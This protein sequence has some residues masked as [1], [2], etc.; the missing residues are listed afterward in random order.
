MSD[1]PSS[2]GMDV[3]DIANLPELQDAAR[4]VQALRIIRL[5]RKH[6]LL[7]SD[8][9]GTNDYLLTPGVN[10]DVNGRVNTY[11]IAVRVGDG[12]MSESLSL[13]INDVIRNPIHIGRDA[14]EPP[15]MLV[16]KPDVVIATTGVDKILGE[17]ERNANNVAEEAEFHAQRRK[18]AI[19]KVVNRVWQP[20]KEF[21]E[22]QWANALGILAFLFVIGVVIALAG[23]GI[24]SCVGAVNRSNEERSRAISDFDKANPNMVLKGHRTD[25]G[26]SGT[27]KTNTADMD[28]GIPWQPSEKVDKY[29]RAY[30]VDTG[31]CSD[32][33]D[34]EKKFD[35]YDAYGRIAGH[36]Y[37]IMETNA[38][39]DM[40]HYW[41]NPTG[42]V[43]LCAT[44][45]AN[46]GSYGPD[47]T[48]WMQTQPKK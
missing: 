32:S 20:T 33:E 25:I 42:L 44:D 29:P 48:V 14:S 15:L 23:W 9:D 24:S 30:T 26:T 27:L 22:E 12:Q 46:E 8:N 34:N 2:S 4:W 35:N 18:Q 43:H 41:I 5:Y 28:K 45:P 36:E 38:P 1:L 37:L 47:Y 7:F 11:R 17:L 13:I 19:V 16:S 3:N 31:S 39:D 21:I 40:V 6:G 10:I